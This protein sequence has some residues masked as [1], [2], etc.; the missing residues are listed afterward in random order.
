[1]ATQP[2]T[3]EEVVRFLMDILGDFDEN[4]VVDE[5]DITT[6]RSDQENESESRKT[7][8]ISTSLAHQQGGGVVIVELDR[9]GE[10]REAQSLLL[11]MR[12]S[13]LVSRKYSPRHYQ[14][15]LSQLTFRVGVI[16][17]VAGK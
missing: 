1:M 10:K 3:V 17:R 15:K 9:T 7:K 4:K 14:N 2:F 8:R 6:D 16:D 5:G 11:P 13:P 12:L